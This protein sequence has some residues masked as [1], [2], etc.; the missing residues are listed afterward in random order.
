[1]KNE[2]AIPNKYL[3]AGEQ[4]DSSLGD[5]YLR[6][7]FY[8]SV[9]GRFTRQDIYEGEISNPLTLHKY[10][11]VHNNPANH[12]DPLGLFVMTEIS[13]AQSISRELERQQTATTVITLSKFSRNAIEVVKAV[14][15]AY[16]STQQIAESLARMFRMPMLVIGWEMPSTTEHITR[17]LLSSGYTKNNSGGSLFGSPQLSPVLSRVQGGTN[18]RAWYKKL[19]VYRNR[20]VGTSID[21]YPYAST[22][23]GGE[24][25]YN[26]NYVSLKAVP[27]VEQN[28]QGGIMP[29]FYRWG[30][31]GDGG[32]SDVT[33]WYLNFA[34]FGSMSYM[35][36]RSGSKR[37][38]SYGA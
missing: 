4:F 13:A 18:D 5:Y 2:G 17:S 20:P 36:D 35:L 19:P 31:V 37:F 12:T 14:A 25:N 24:N 27:V 9:N 6:D 29:N 11:Y 33:S 16:A 7:R 23:Q 32:M 26:N 28:R 8:S 30:M 22:A 15:R 38:F 34:H 3:F 21:E 10:T 1:M